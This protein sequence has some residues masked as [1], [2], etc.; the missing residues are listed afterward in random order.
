MVE[1]LSR[2]TVV[3]SIGVAAALA[4]TGRRGAYGAEATNLG[5]VSFPGPSISSHSKVV[6]KALKLDEKR[7]WNL[8]WETRPTSESYYNDFVTGAYQ[9]IDFGGLNVFANLHNKGVPL[10]LVQATVHWPTPLVVRVDDGFK[11]LGDLAGKKIGV[12]RSSFAYAYLSS[13]VKGAGLKVDKDVTLENVGFFQAP[14]RFM[15]GDFDAVVMLFE[16]AIDMM[17]KAP[18]KY[19]ILVDVSDEFAK[20]SGLGR[21][22]QFQ[23]VR[24]DWLAQ[25]KDGIEKVMA[26]YADLGLAFKERPEE[27]VTLLAKP[28]EEMGAALDR[29]I[30]EVEYIKGAEGLKTEWLSKPVASFTDAIEYEFEE[31]RLLGLIERIPDREIFIKGA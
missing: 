12:D 18:G 30:G 13:S 7:G 6:I 5:I 20:R 2:R 22:Y 28:K 19:R 10:K 11:K 31:Y 9:S 1:R 15:R 4:A 21:T 26:T 8:R 17:N 29:A 14:P 27:A 16:H 23:A 24:T 25:N 3:G